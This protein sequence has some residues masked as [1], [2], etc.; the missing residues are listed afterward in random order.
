MAGTE[1]V[2]DSDLEA[3]SPTCW[4]A[5]PQAG[6]NGWIGI[7][8]LQP[9]TQ[10]HRSGRQSLKATFSR[11]EDV[12]SAIRE[13]EGSRHVKVGFHDRYDAGFDFAA[14]MKILRLSSFD[15]A[16]QRNN[17]DIVLESRA[18]RA[19]DNYCGQTD[20]TYLSIA[21]NGGPV[22]WGIVDAPFVFERGRWYAIQVEVHLNQPGQADGQLRV[23]VDQ[24]KVIER[25]GMNL[26]GS[27][28]APINRVGFGGWYS[29]AAAGRNP[30][31]D[32]A[33]P[34]THYLDDLVI[35]A[36]PN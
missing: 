18:S 10:R 30:C 20:T 31:P 13:I 34:S 4:A 32:P 2:F 27:S 11:N 24:Q 25:N 6:C 15:A 16:A 1:L 22:D 19:G 36:A 28:T 33:A 3:E 23:W 26:V 12:G 17:F 9:S 7:H 35:R 21:Y 5:P 29:N 8:G 14:G